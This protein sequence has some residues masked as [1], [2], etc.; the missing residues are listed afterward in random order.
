MVAGTEPA[1]ALLSRLGFGMWIPPAYARVLEVCDSLE[2]VVEGNQNS[3]LDRVGDS[4]VRETL[5][6]R[7]EGR[8]PE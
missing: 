6:R 2:G 4:V 7:S 1:A 8:E 5:G 3:C